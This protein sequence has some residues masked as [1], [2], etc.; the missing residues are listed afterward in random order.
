MWRLPDQVG[1]RFKEPTRRLSEAMQDWLPPP[2]K[3][4]DEAVGLGQAKSAPSLPGEDLQP[5][6]L[7]QVIAIDCF[8]VSYFDPL[9]F[10][11]MGPPATYDPDSPVGASGI[12]CQRT[13]AMPGSFL[14][15]TSLL[16]ILDS[17]ATAERYVRDSPL[18][19]RSYKRY[20]A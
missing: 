20:V 19:R 7:I 6:S 15:T 14:P 5:T 12:G 4:K 8:P 16:A 17:I 10:Y 1:S 13:T 18:P 9:T 2:F 11:L 3:E